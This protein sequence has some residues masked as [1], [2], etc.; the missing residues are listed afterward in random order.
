MPA[1]LRMRFS[2]MAR[3]LTG[4]GVLV[5]DQHAVFV[6]L[7]AGDDVGV[8]GHAGNGARRDA[9]LGDLVALVGS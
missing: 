5:A 6:V 9:A 4:V 2:I 8:A 3:R 1:T 7:V